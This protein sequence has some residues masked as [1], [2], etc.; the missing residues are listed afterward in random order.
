MSPGQIDL[1]PLFLRRSGLCRLLSAL[2]RRCLARWNDW[3]QYEI[4][5]P[6][7]QVQRRLATVDF[8]RPVARIVVQERP[9][10]G[11]LVLHVGKLAAR[12]A[13]IDVITS[14]HAQ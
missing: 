4:L 6:V 13:R 7:S 12:T 11:E 5:A 14:A 2:R 10:P 1:S 9:V 3:Q 8:Q